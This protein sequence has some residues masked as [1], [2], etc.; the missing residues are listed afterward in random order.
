MGA[1]TD[2]GSWNYYETIG[3]GMGGG[4]V[5]AGLSGVQTHMTNTLN[6][7]IESLEMHY[8]LRVNRYQIRR[9]SGGLGAQKGGD[10]LIREI[11][12]LTPANVTLLTERRTHRPWGVLGGE[13]GAYGENQLNGKLLTERRTHRPWGVLGGEGGAYGE[14]QLN[15]KALPAK[16]SLEAKAGDCL[17]IKTPGAGGYGVE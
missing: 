9:D 14:N 6:T 4:R 5:N 2:A 1:K 3:G 11:Q 8:P 10:G 7:P 15:G 12:F 16:V 13:G 17:T